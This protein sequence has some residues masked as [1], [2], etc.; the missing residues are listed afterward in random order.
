M[1]PYLLV[2]HSFT[3]WIVL[4]LMISSLVLCIHGLITKRNFTKPDHLF[5]ILTIAFSHFQLVLGFFL[6]FKS[7]IVRSF[8]SDPAGSLV[9]ADS[10]FFTLIHISLMFIS[11]ILLTVGSAVSK[12]KKEEPDKFKN[13]LVWN[14]IA[15]ILILI[16]IPWPFSPL[17]TRPYLR[18]F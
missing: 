9:I 7:P 18:G 10:R 1:Y 13:L 16:A 4:F 5:R 3:R 15:L 11:V 12:R 8:F 14:S 2:F 6:Y 17:A